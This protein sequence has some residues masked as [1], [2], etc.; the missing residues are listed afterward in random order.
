M[1]GFEHY[2]QEISNLDHEIRHY[3][4]VAGIHLENR[5]EVEQCLNPAPGTVTAG[6]PMDTLRGLMI[7]RLKVEAEM[8]EQGMLA[9]PLIPQA[10]A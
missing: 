9:P 6:S 10:K 8:V 5:F 7:L 3:A 2:H 4:A 1:S